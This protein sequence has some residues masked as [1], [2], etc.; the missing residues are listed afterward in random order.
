M[1]GVVDT[2]RMESGAL[3]V[4]LAL[5]VSAAWAAS[6]PL[7]L[8]AGLGGVAMAVRRRAVPLGEGALGSGPRVRA[9][10]SAVERAS[11]ADDGGSLAAMRLTLRRLEAEL[12]ALDDQRRTDRAERDGG[13]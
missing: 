11:A 3:L 13:G 10:P 9:V 5:L 1:D 2:E 7:A 8:L 4:L 12:Y 6:L